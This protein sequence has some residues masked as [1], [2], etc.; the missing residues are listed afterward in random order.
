[1][2]LKISAFKKKKSPIKSVYNVASEPLQD[3]K[4]L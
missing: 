4:I 2:K 3:L 1:M